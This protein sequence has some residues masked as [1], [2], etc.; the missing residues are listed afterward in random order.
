MKKYGYRNSL[1][2]LLCALLFTGTFS[3]C[4]KSGDVQITA[5]E[6]KPILTEKERAI[7]EKMDDM[8]LEEKVGQLFVLALRQTSYDNL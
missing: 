7:Q 2:L 1:A 3:G 8:S 6:Q 4:E 5:G